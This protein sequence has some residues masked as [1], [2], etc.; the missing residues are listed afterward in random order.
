MISSREIEVFL[1]RQSHL[2][3]SKEDTYEILKV[4]G[5]YESVLKGRTVDMSGIIGRGQYKLIRELISSFDSNRVKME[6]DGAYPDAQRGRMI[7]SIAEDEREWVSGLVILELRLSGL[8]CHRD[9]LGAL[10]S[11]GVKR[12]K[13]GDIGIRGLIAYVIVSEDMTDFIRMSLDRI[14]KA[15]VEASDALLPERVDFP[16]ASIKK[17]EIIAASLRADLLLS[18]AFKR[19]RKDVKSDI[20]KGK[21]KLNDFIL[22]TATYCLQDADVI[23]YRNNGKI[24]MGKLKG[25]SKKGN[26]IVEIKKYV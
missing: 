12:S 15:K 14:G 7:F 22:D 5:A 6:F 18:K 3:H 10:L 2:R 11:L 26:T 1:N 8:V 20:E 23:S 13:I 21:V 17:I 4:I 25:T 16:K 9:V 19:S 24:E